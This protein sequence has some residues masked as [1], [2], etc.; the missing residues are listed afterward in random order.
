MNIGAARVECC[1]HVGELALH[2][3]E[4][5]NRMSE[6]LAPAYIG[7]AKIE[8]G[9]HDAERPR[10]E[11]N[12]LIIKTRHQNLD[13]MIHLAQHV[14]FWHF[15]IFEHKFAGGGAAHA[16]L[17]QLLARAESVKSV[18]NEKRRDAMCSG[19]RIGLRIN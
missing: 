9:L 14:F 2:E 8:T 13:A 5:P 17:V 16:K 10:R 7:Q 19:I 12:P 1:I 11:N 15:A 6:L 4:L 3:L 18:L